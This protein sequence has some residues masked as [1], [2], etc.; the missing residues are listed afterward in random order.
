MAKVI[1]FG[2][3]DF[4]S[5]AH[6]YLKH[7][8][9]HQVVAFTAN[10]DFLHGMDRFE[11]LPV[12]PFEE[13]DALFPPPE[14]HFF[15]PMSHRNMNRVREKIV[16][17]AK[18]K[19]YSF[20]SYVSSK[21]ITFPGFEVR[22]N[23]FILE[24]NIIQP[25]ARIGSNVILWSGNYIGHHSVIGDHVFCAAH[26][27]LSGHC[28]VGSHAFLGLNATIRDGLTI[29]QGSLIAMGACV[30][31]STEE[32]GVYMGNPARKGDIPSYALDF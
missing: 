9:D 17:Q 14:H 28:T 13:I 19:N 11:G 18:A 26:V 2:V 22:E 24:G 8:S 30:T 12:I 5:L 32:W 16:H 20:I 23:C 27:T 31:R 15:S 10:R 4:A 21:A 25:F 3:R 6:F 29:A 7:D 1:I